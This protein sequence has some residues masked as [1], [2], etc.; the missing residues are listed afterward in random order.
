MKNYSDWGTSLK[1][2]C[3]LDGY[4]LEMYET[5]ETTTVS[6]I[7]K[8]LNVN[9]KTVYR[10]ISYCAGN[11]YKAKTFFYMMHAL[12]FST[13]GPYYELQQQ[14]LENMKRIERKMK[15]R[16]VVKELLKMQESRIE[17]QTKSDKVKKLK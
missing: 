1:M 12:E 2:Q 3:L 16:M 5:G 8:E 4:F 17:N 6:R 11:I 13:S 10:Y 7:C 14:Y 15:A 9:S